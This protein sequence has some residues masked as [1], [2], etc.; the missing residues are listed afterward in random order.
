VRSG[1]SAIVFVSFAYTGLR[2]QVTALILDRDYCKN[3]R[4]RL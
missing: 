3:I 4:P 2:Q 1:L